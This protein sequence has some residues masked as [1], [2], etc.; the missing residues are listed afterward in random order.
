MV[1]ARKVVYGLAEVDALGIG[2]VGA[3]MQGVMA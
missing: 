1:E 3:Q 2:Y